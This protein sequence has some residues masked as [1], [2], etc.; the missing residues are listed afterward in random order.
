MAGVGTQCRHTTYVRPCQTGHLGEL[1]LND[2]LMMGSMQ[3]MIVWP[4]RRGVE[5][6]NSLQETQKWLNASEKNAA[7][8]T[9]KCPSHFQNAIEFLGLFKILLLCRF[10]SESLVDGL[11]F[12]CA[13][14]LPGPYEPRPNLEKWNRKTTHAEQDRF[15]ISSLDSRH[16]CASAEESLPPAR[17]ILV[18]LQ[19]ALQQCAGDGLHARLQPFHCTKGGS[20]VLACI[21][22]GEDSGQ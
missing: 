18:P 7:R 15:Q 21:D 16:A 14:S 6:R 19:F 20:N 11:V 17:R 4:C 10:R 1:G 9:W 3:P 8:M 12:D 13:F 5:E 22:H 2:A